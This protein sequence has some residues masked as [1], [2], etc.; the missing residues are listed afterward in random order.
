MSGADAL[1]TDLLFGPAGV[2]TARA[3]RECQIADSV[4]R[5]VGPS[6]A[7]VRYERALDYFAKACE[8][9]ARSEYEAERRAGAFLRSGND[10]L[11]KALGE[12]AEGYAH[13]ARAHYLDA[14]ENYDKALE[15]FA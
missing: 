1:R 10:Q 3:V 9:L 4:L 6:L 5:D 12:Y 7:T 13:S 14:F 8:Q 15:L 11:Q 2:N